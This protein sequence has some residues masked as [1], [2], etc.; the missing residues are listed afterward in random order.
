MAVDFLPG[1]AGFDPAGWQADQ[2]FASELV[3]FDALIQN[4]DRTWRNPN[5]LVWHDN[6]WLI[7]HGSALY[8]QHNWP[9]ARPLAAFHAKEIVLRPAAS[10]WIRL[11]R[12]SRRG[13]PRIC[14]TRSSAWCR[15]A[16]S[17][18]AGP[19]TMSA[20]CCERAPHVLEVIR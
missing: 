8:F 1:P 12:C 2:D 14:S 19:R 15:P 17:A 11:T 3:W 6:I 9:T 7:D 5:L 18:T 16:G 4:V 10:G 13:S 20:S